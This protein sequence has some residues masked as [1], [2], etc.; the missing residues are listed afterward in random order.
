MK[1]KVAILIMVLT[2]VGIVACFIPYE[3]ASQMS[4]S[5]IN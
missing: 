1:K 5:F 2:L 4:D 3:F